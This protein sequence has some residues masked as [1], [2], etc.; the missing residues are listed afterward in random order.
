MLQTEGSF[1]AILTTTQRLQATQTAITACEAGQSFS[2]DG[3][4]F[5]RANIE[6][7]YKREK[8]LEAKLA[9]ENGS[10]PFMK[11]VNLSGMG[12]S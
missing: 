4:S 6:S 8:Y 3:V 11:T 5:T 2:I 1:L 9:K 7:L 10:R 12:Y